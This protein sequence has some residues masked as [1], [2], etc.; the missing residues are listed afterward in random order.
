MAGNGPKR[1]PAEV[2]IAKGLYRP[3]RHGDLETKIKPEFLSEVPAPPNGMGEYAAKFWND[4]LGDLLKIKGLITFVDLPSF[5]IMA[6]KY[7]TIMECYDLLKVQSKWVTDHNGNTKENPVCVTL[8]KA[9]KIF[10]QLAT[11][12]GCTPAARNN[13]KQ[14][15][16]DKPNEPQVN[17]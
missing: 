2:A 5:Q 11:Q 17:L 14:P 15:T 4:T 12:F 16:Q 6:L 8:E 9:E 3:S 13:L 1:Q 10:I 7:Q